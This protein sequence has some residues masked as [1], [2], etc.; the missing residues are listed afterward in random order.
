MRLK[1]M[2]IKSVNVGCCQVYC[3]LKT[4]ISS[5]GTS[6]QPWHTAVGTAPDTDVCPGMITD[7][8]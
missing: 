4:V 5:H 6:A 2:Q 1:E 7:V 3:L 8:A